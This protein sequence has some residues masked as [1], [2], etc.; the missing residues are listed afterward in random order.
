[1]RIHQEK[2]RPAA[3]VTVKKPGP[4]VAH[5][6]VVPSAPPPEVPASQSTLPQEEL[7]L[8][9]Q[10]KNSTLPSGLTLPAGLEPALWK[11]LNALGLG[12]Y[13]VILVEHGFDD[14]AT[15][16]LAEVGHLQGLGV[17]MGH[18]LKLLKAVKELVPPTSN[19]LQ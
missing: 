4:A 3:S 8:G 14:S 18:G 12:C 2:L 16:S 9:G 15:L 11:L 5:L 10:Q 1:M 17:K 13:G 19:R 6:A 7:E